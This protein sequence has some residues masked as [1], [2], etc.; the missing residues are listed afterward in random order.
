M[1]VDWEY[2]A[3]SSKDLAARQNGH[4]SIDQCTV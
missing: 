3:P 2:S 1:T 4:L